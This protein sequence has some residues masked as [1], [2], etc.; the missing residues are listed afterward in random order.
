MTRHLLSPFQM[1]PYALKN[2]IV[3]APLTRCRADNPERAP[4]G[5]HAEYYRQRAGAGLIISEGAPVSPMA[6]GYPYTPGIYTPEQVA[7]WKKVTQ[8]VHDAGG[9]IFCQLWH[10]GRISHPD[11]LEGKRPLAPSAINP[12]T[13]H[14]TLSGKKPTVVPK[15]MTVTEIHRTTDEF[16]KA[17]EHAMEAGFDGVEIHA[18]NG[19]LFHQFL[20]KCA[21]TRKDDYGGSIENRCRF[22]LETTDAVVNITGP[23]KTG[24]RLNPYLHNNKGIVLDEETI[25]LYDYLVDKLN[26]YP[27]AY[28]HLT[29]PFTDIPGHPWGYPEVARHFRPIY[30]GALIINK[31]FTYP[32]G[33]RIIQQGN[34][35]LVAFGKL[36]ISNPDL[37][38]RFARGAP[39]NPWDESTFYTQGPAGYTDYPALSD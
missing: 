7:G 33:N 39:L 28:L 35:D 24:I 36:F 9:I 8:A 16:R 2:R 4:T 37:P 21:N 31:G 10:V 25:P 13:M 20:A 17:A 22:L 12:R 32:S 29:E 1:G 15:A 26:H 11:Y 14:R 23:G 30:N 6:I 38:E 34:A 5:L 3:M 18:A 19:Y 27:L